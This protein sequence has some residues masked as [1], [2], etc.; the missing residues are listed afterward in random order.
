MKQAGLWDPSAAASKGVHLVPPMSYLQFLRLQCEARMVITDS[1]GVQ[2]ET[3]ALGVPCLTVR[4]NTERP[5]TVSEGSNVLVGLNARRLV[6]EARKILGGKG[7][8]GNG[9]A[10][11]D[12]RASERIVR[13]LA[14]QFRTNHPSGTEGF[15]VSDPHKQPA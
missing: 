11:W 10:L 1:G 15:A 9:P 2:E 14:V 6:A 8:K 3:T 7:K 13:T 12:G 5:I 4:E